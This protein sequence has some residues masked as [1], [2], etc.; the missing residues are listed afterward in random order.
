MRPQESMSK[1]YM[2]FQLDKMRNFRYGMKALELIEDTLGMPISKVDFNSLTMKQLKVVIWAGLVHEDQSLKPDDVFELID[3]Y[4][5]LDTV[6]GSMAKA[7]EEAFGKNP[8][9]A[10]AKK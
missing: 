9:R 1:V 8:V 5:D 10:A 7:I 4:S 2:P 3:E 6:T